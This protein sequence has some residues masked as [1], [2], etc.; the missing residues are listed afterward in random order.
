MTYNTDGIKDS[1]IA[2]AIH[3]K[4]ENYIKA[5]I[6]DS[7]FWIWSGS[8]K[9]IQHHY[10]KGG[11]ATHTWE[12][13]QLSQ[14]VA[15]KY[16]L[17]LDE[18]QQL[19]LAA[20]Y[21]DIGKICDYEPVRN[22]FNEFDYNEWQKTEHCRLIHHIPR[23][24]LIFNENCNPWY[25]YKDEVIHCILSHHGQKEWG[26]PV[27]PRTKIAWILHLCDGLS[28]RVDDCGGVHV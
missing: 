1:I 28:A 27:Q 13:I 26:S 3:L 17:T 19:F 8:S 18:R 25:K 5:V 14:M 11:L 10:G 9:P 24:T 15:E 22:E 16:K 21:H 2:V 23:S 4:A 6:D 12:V 20:L 7:R